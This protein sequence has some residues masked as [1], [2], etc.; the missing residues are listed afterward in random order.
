MITPEEL[1]HWTDEEMK[2][3][4]HE[5]PHKTHGQKLCAGCAAARCRRVVR[6]VIAEYEKREYECRGALS[7]AINELEMAVQGKW[8]SSAYVKN[9]RDRIIRAHDDLCVD[10]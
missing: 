8:N 10:A 5:C 3:A 2:R 6:E 7:T 4:F 9:V 1:E